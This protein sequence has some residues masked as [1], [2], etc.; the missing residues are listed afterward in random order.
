MLVLTNRNDLGGISTPADQELKKG[1]V[2]IYD[3]FPGGIGLSRQAY[4]M[5]QDLLEKGREVV[6]V[7]PCSNGCPACIH[8]PKCGS[9]NRPLD[10]EA[11]LVLLE[12]MLKNADLPG[13]GLQKSSK[14][15]RPVL[16]KTEK[17]PAKTFSDYA[18]LDIETR[19]SAGEAGGWG[20]T[21]LMGVSCAVVYDSLS[22]DFRTFYQE[23]T[24]AL[25]RYLSGFSMVIGF[26][27]IY[28]D[29]RVLKGQSNFDFSS[30]PTLDILLEI[31]KRL[32]HRLSLDHLA[33]N[34]LGTQKTADGLEALKWWKQGRIEDIVKYCTAD[35]A[36]TRDLFL[37]G[38]KY[39]H[40]VYR[41]KA[42]SKV[43]IPVDWPE[44]YLNREF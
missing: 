2:F 15:V 35:V 5:L 7:C 22:R 30:L 31:K 12:A 13:A 18:V 6:S 26:T 36:I 41:N 3:G 16:K 10:K 20:N 4:A 34:T 25:G 11:A 24:D 40:L 23:D 9:G 17:A 14:S 27:L 43:R 32:G 1:A 33:G 28:F 8:S 19:K 39:G 44:R 29:Y 42:G 38:F 37:Y 21:H